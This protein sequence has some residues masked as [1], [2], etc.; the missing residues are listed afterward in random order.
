MTTLLLL[1]LVALGVLLLNALLLW[2]IARL[3]R[4]ERAS[5]A[6][7]SLAVLLMALAQ[8]VILAAVQALPR[9]PAVATALALQFVLLLVALVSAWGIIVLVFR[10]RAG[11]SALIALAHS[12][13][14]AVL[15]IGVY[16]GLLQLVQAFVV[17]TNGMAP[18]LIGHHYR[19]TCPHCQGTAVVSAA[20]RIEGIPELP[21]DE[22]QN[23]ICTRCLQIAEY[24]DH[25]KT[26]YGP[27]RFLCSRFL[28]ANRWDLIVFRYPREP[29]TRYVD[30]LVGLPGETIQIKEKAVWINGVKAEPPADIGALTYLPQPDFDLHP[31]RGPSQWVLGPEEYF[32]LGDF[33]TN[34][35]DSRDWGPVPAENIEAVATLIYWPPSRWRIVR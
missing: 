34:A 1:L 9:P 33:T 26:V 14:S 10:S 3:F 32:V 13:A 20:R 15:A 27:D 6:R 25:P 31:Q 16:F 29:E 22:P 8:G 19:V 30:R 5:L 35:S 28:K 11:K 4:V 23:G 21:A 2:G 7:A 12:L 24:R 17:P 18:T